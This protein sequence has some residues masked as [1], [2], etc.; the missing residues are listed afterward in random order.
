MDATAAW[1]MGWRHFPVPA[2]T[3]K[4]HAH[5]FYPP[6]SHIDFV[7]TWVEQ[8]GQKAKSHT[9][10][11]RARDAGCVWLTSVEVQGY[12]RSDQFDAADAAAAE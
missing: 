12:L 4:S 1:E 3:T 11:A 5:R 8:G 2:I 7:A 6:T 9:S 10:P